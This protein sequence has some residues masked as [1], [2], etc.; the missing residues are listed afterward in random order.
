MGGAVKQLQGSQLLRH[1]LSSAFNQKQMNF[2]LMKSVLKIHY[3][4]FYV[5][6]KKTNKQKNIEVDSC[7]VFHDF[8]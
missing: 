4:Y 3:N 7:V 8:M 5:S 2:C 1:A 6:A